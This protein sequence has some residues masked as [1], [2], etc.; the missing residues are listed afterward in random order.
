MHDENRITVLG[1]ALAPLPE[2]RGSSP[3]GTSGLV[4]LALLNDGLCAIEVALSGRELDEARLRLAYPTMWMAAR[5]YAKVLEPYQRFEDLQPGRAARFLRHH[6][7]DP[8]RFGGA[9][10]QTR[11]L[12]LDICLRLLHAGEGEAWAR[13]E[14]LM[15]RLMDALVTCG[16]LSERDARALAA[17]RALLAERRAAPKAP[18]QPSSLWT[19]AFRFQEGPEVFSSIT[20]A[21]HVFEPD[22]TDVPTLHA[23]AREALRDLLERQRAAPE[24]ESGRWL[25][26]LGRAGS[27][28]THLLRAFRDQL[29]REGA[30]LCSYT[31]LSAPTERTAHMI[32]LRTVDSLRQP[33]LVGERSGLQRLSDALAQGLSETDQQQLSGSLLSPSAL[34][35]FLAK[36]ADALMA[37]P[38]LSEL[39]VDL[40]RTLLALQRPEP[41]A[42]ARALKW[43]RAEDME[44][45]D[46]AALGGAVP[47][48]Q[49]GA[50]L[51]ILEQLGLLSW[52]LLR[53]PLVFLFDQTE[54]ALLGDARRRAQLLE[55]L[56]H[57]G[58]KLP[59]SILV[60]ACQTEAFATA[61]AHLPEP[62]RDR[63]LHSPS[64]VL[65]TEAL[66]RPQVE[67]LIGARLF[68]LRRR[69]GLR[70]APPH[71][72]APLTEPQLEAM[73]ALTPR[74]ALQICAK[75]QRIELRSFPS[76]RSPGPRRWTRRSPARC[77]NPTPPIDPSPSRPRAQTRPPKRK[78]PPHATRRPWTR[79]SSRRRTK[80]IWAPRSARSW[81]D[82]F[83]R[84]SPS[85]S[86]ARTPPPC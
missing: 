38:R 41:S 25:V 9:C 77:L 67:A 20:D 78:R 69:L 43:L 46:R 17:L 83:M 7:L 12:G 81:I 19:Q 73:L 13:Y 34:S 65:L 57:L 2:R 44:P 8:S 23:Q 76:R 26:V 80:P 74:E 60:L 84:P 33:Y 35:S 18:A 1:P 75:L 39:D 6:R 49:E 70:R 31:Q 5:F 62:L 59:A 3:L 56:R 71:P 15:V 48:L 72:C 16:S 36:S 10:A 14:R 58:E 61:K 86:W 53:A 64:P 11:W 82:F 27:G 24:P 22:P 21:A 51:F 45:A 55:V 79:R 32:L 52:A 4:R 47:K 40:I 28:K 66:E 50:P 63:A 54:D 30:A 85:R 29:H 68:D 37:D 42:H